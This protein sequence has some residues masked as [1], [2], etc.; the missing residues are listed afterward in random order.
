MIVNFK[1]RAY[2]YT[3]VYQSKHPHHPRNEGKVSKGNRTEKEFSPPTVALIT[4][5]EQLYVNVVMTT[6]LESQSHLVFPCP[7][8]MFD[9]TIKA[10]VQK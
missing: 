6:I 1:I 7:L 4:S 2:T 9:D 8:L 10:M 3:I 5:S